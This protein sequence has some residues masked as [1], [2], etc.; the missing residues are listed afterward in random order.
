MPTQDKHP[1]HTRSTG[2]T[3]PPIHQ[4]YSQTEL[5]LENCCQ[6]LARC[7]QHGISISLRKGKG[8]LWF[9][10][11]VSMAFQIQFCLT[12]SA[13]QLKNSKKTP[14][15]QLKNSKHLQL[16]HFPSHPLKNLNCYLLFYNVA[17]IF[18]SFQRKYRPQSRQIAPISSLSYLPMCS[19]LRKRPAF[20]TIQPFQIG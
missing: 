10:Y 3:N 15:H 17:L 14:T 7:A 11:G 13:R 18:T 1:S 5:L 9:A 16:T 8:T 2:Q 20:C 6:Q 12:I 4:L 19:V